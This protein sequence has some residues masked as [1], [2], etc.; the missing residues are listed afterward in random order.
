MMHSTVQPEPGN[1]A[2]ATSNEGSLTLVLGG[3]RSGK[4]AFAQS[5]AARLGG[6]RVLFVAT[7]QPH[8]DEMQRRIDHHRRSRSAAWQTLEQS[9]H[10]GQG[11]ANYLSEENSQAATPPVILLDCL[12]LLVSNVMCDDEQNC[13]DADELERRVRSEVDALIEVATNHPTH[14]IIVSGEVGSGVVPEHAMGRLFRDL[15]G[16]GNQQLAAVATSTYL[17]VAGLAIDATR[18]STS[19]EQA[20][21]LVNATSRQESRV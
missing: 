14:L 7:A 13:Q 10:V 16:M 6:E 11:I 18:L 17:M 4:S 21:D 5:L 20:A 15:L 8:D 2:A 9:L 3:V 1:A 19:V 12:T